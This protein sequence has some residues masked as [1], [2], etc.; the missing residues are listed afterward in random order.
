VN[1][2]TRGSRW[3]A[4][5]GRLVLCV[6]M[7]SMTLR[8]GGA[9][10]QALTGA[11][12]GEEGSVEVPPLAS[13]RPLGGLH[14][15]AWSER[16]DLSGMD[17]P[18]WALAVDGSGNLYAGGDFLTAGGVSASHVAMWNG[19]SW[20]ALGGGVEGYNR[21][22]WALAEDSDGTL[23]MGGYFATVG[24]VTA[25][26]IA[27]WDGS[28]WSALGSGTDHAVYALAPDGSGNLYAGGEFSTAGGV[29]ASHI[30]MWDGSA[31]SGSSWRGPP[32]LF[33]PLVLRDWSSAYPPMPPYGS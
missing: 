17:S 9:P 32:S 12:H 8:L 33:L 4:A 29:S 31:W 24:G 30:A 22:V 25:N 23:Y 1:A 13:G 6:A 18:V 28:S 3:P 11:G 19:S 2:G 14:H 7:F 10:V 15:P 27:C 5:L 16:L 20:S 21:G 26:H